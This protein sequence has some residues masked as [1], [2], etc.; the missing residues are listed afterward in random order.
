ML[1]FYNKIR[2]L[3]LKKVF[4]G[5][6][7]MSQ[8]ARLGPAGRTLPIPV[9]D[10]Q[11]TKFFYYYAREAFFKVASLIAIKGRWEQLLVRDPDKP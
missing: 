11:A 6:D 9:L 1:H 2:Y 10:P 5:P 3:I 4:R 8:R 7:I